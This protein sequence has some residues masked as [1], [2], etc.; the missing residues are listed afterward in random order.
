[1]HVAIL[2]PVRVGTG[3]ADP[4]P[5]AAAKQRVILATLA[6]RPNHTVSTDFLTEALWPQAKPSSAKAAV[7]NYV[8]RLR[9]TMGEASG[10]LRTASGG[11]LLDVRDP[12]ELDHLHAAALESRARDAL[13]GGGFEAGGQLAD[14][15]LA[16]WRGD[17]LE[18]VPC[19]R[20]Q[21]DCRPALDALRLRLEETRLDALL[22]LGQFERALPLLSALIAAHPFLDTLHER[23]LVALYGAGRRTEALDA[24]RAVRARLREAVG[25]DPSPCLR[26]LHQLVLQEAPV[27]EV[28]AVWRADRE[29]AHRG[30]KHLLPAPAAPSQ[31][32]PR[33]RL[34]VGRRT[35]LAALTRLLAGPDEARDPRDARDASDAREAESV[36]RVGVLSG[37]AGVGKT[38]VALTWAH[39]AAAAFPDGRM[40]L[41]LNGFA[42]D[43]RPLST[44]AAVS[45]LLDFL[46]VPPEEVPATPQGRAALYRSRVA[47]RRVLLVIDNA[48]D[49]SQ[50]RPLLPAGAARALVT[51]RRCL[52]GLVALDGAEALTLEPLTAADSHELLAR[53][54]G[55]GRVSGRE[56]AIEAIADR[57]GNLPLALAVAAARAVVL[58]NVPLE[59]LAAQLESNALNALNPG[60][61]TSDVRNV[62]SWSYRQLPAAAART[63]RFLGLHPGPEITVPAVAALA[64]LPPSEA[65][66]LVAELA[67]VNLLTE[68]TLGR[69]TMHGLVR[70]FATELVEQD[71]TAEQRRAAQ[72]RL[73]EY[74][75]LWA[76]AG[77]RSHTSLPTGIEPDRVPL[78]PG[79]AARPFTE[80]RAGMAWLDQEQNVLMALVAH[81]A[82]AGFDS[83]AW[84]LAATQSCSLMLRGR[85]HDDARQAR[86]GLAAAKRLGDP[87]AQARAYRQIGRALAFAGEYDTARFQ[88]GRALRLY[89][90]LGDVA[91]VCESERGLAAAHP[92]RRD[93]RAGQD[94]AA[95]GLGACSCA[96]SD[97]IGTA[98]ASATA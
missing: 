12:C 65:A 1:M 46:G 72:H 31:L 36:C 7:L 74:H 94:H 32:P 39:E 23:R 71:T 33:P 2:G 18:D 76:V 87:A 82:A 92:R 84:R 41:D 37:P 20:L 49:A 38:T 61:D 45:A 48:R 63:L 80:E 91:G 42:A 95:G 50:A 21:G 66:P 29:V 69:Y 43:G 59:A 24:Y 98:A 67:A 86:I 93:H 68:T 90:S 78:P 26:L 47:A 62:L 14:E 28:V 5:V 57:C 16:L 88:F 53:R 30:G 8:A 25:S 15:G 54:L 85:W 83:Y 22:C 27:S 13:C 79:L 89:R 64:D 51:S 4:T 77:E 6:L 55:P 9:R 34:V 3:A 96:C 58:A 60:D 40:Y 81:A 73:L 52:T 35:E 44:D 56:R 10:R 70:A 75:L 17:P 19:E 11:Y 97:T